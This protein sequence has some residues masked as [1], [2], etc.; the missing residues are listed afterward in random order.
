[1]GSQAFAESTGFSREDA[2][3]FIDEYFHDFSGI[4][5]YMERTKRFAEENGYVE[6]LFG[7]RRY[8]PEIHSPNWQLKREAERMAINMPIQGTATG[9]IIKL[10]MIKVEQWIKKEKLGEDVRMLLQV[11]DELLF[12]IKEDLVKQIAPRI[13]EIMEKII[14][15]KMPLVVDVKVGKNWGDQNNT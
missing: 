10:A 2:K 8:I 4:R 13:K 3:K 14:Q 12:E 7:R 9:D 11:H 5:E 15:L 1:M 6:T